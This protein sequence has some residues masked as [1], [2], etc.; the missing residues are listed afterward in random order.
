MQLSHDLL[1]LKER[2]AGGKEA[3]SERAEEN[4]A[5][6]V[7]IL[8]KES[9]LKAIREAQEGK[10]RVV[11]EEGPYALDSPYPYTPPPVPP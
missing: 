7:K 2:V 10:V 4:V 1:S 11:R 5:L 9:M 8:N 3:I 6:E